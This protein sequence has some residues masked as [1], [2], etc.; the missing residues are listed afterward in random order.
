[1]VAAVIAA[2]AAATVSMGATFSTPSA[3]AAFASTGLISLA[4]NLVLLLLPGLYKNNRPSQEGA[5]TTAVWLVLGQALGAGGLL[6]DVFLHTLAET[7]NS[8]TTGYYILM[9]FTIFFS[10]DLLIR[11]LN[12]SSTACHVNHHHQQHTGDGNTAP[13]PY[14]SSE[15]GDST[16]SI[17]ATDDSH[18]GTTMKRSLILLNLVA[19]ALHNF[20][21]G[22]AIGATYATTSTD[23]TSLSTELTLSSVWTLLKTHS[24]GGLATLSILFHEIPHEL[25]KSPRT[26]SP[27]LR[28]LFCY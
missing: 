2:A 27:L 4:P 28:L 1:L 19:D 13:S 9:G 3:L 17:L 11:S 12:D 26:T 16:R 5:T 18:S 10:V 20:T 14:S 23:A 15:N 24:R 21:D 22:L 6:A 8:S 7:T 25:S